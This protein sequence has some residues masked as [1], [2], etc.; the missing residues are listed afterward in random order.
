MELDVDDT[1]AYGSSF[2]ASKNTNVE[3]EVES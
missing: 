3:C 2:C 1:Q